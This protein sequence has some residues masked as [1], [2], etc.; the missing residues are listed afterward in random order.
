V[1]ISFSNNVTFFILAIL[2]FF[3]GFNT[4]EP[5]MQSLVSKYIKAHKRGFILSFFNS[6]GYLG[7]FIGAL[8]GAVFVTYEEHIILFCVVI[9][10]ICVVWL[11]FI[12]ILEKPHKNKN[13]YLEIKNFDVET[14]SYLNNY[15]WCKDWYI[16]NSEKILIV[17]YDSQ[18]I[19]AKEA[20]A[21]AIKS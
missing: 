17:K 6:C 2:V 1:F 7:S 19:K 4:H 18:I 16:N 12:Y 8:I 9:V 14:Y 5:I 3:I 20:L 21:L 11:I 10:A 15:K 13:L